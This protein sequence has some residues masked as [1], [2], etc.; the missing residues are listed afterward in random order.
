MLVTQNYTDLGRP[1]SLKIVGPY[2]DACE[3]TTDRGHGQ[4]VA[5]HVAELH[6][7]SSGSMVINCRFDIR[8]GHSHPSYGTHVVS[9]TG[10]LCEGEIHE[11]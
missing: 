8:P 4:S 10:D 7:R 5:N 2:Y 9:V 11:S 3:L 1:K 6:R